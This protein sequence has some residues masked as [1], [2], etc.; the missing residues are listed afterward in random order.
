MP[1]N[2]TILPV[3][4]TQS[5]KIHLGLKEIA[6]RVRTQLKKE[7]PWCTFS[8]QKDT[9]SIRIVLLRAPFEAFVPELSNTAATSEQIKGLAN[10]RERGY[11]Q[12]NHYYIEDSVF[13]TEECKKVLLR[14]KEL[15]DTY[16]YDNSDSQSDYFDVNFY[17]HL[18]IGEWD[19]PFRRI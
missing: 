8:V 16:N 10:M 17:L 18:S 3:A 7:F 9:H 14:V 19:K 1:T 12:V 11:L 6:K 4:L 2:T 13:Y 5:E 15:T